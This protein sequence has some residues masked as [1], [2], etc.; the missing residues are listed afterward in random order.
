VDLR[1]P[2]G[3]NRHELKKRIKHKGKKRTNFK[4][5]S[6]PPGR[7]IGKGKGLTETRGLNPTK[8]TILRGHVEELPE[9]GEISQRKED[10]WGE[11]ANPNRRGLPTRRRKMEKLWKGVFVYLSS[12]KIVRRD[13]PQVQEERID[14]QIKVL[15]V[16]KRRGKR[17][18]G[19]T[20]GPS[21][22]AE[23]AH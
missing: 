14:S 22:K 15:K 12:A 1:G 6:I 20:L 21:K 10:Y 9:G 18:R 4:G 11:T 23:T 7:R 19:C 17:I 13:L 8:K 5:V 16:K 2:N 3:R